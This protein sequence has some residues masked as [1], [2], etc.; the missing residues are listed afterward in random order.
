[1]FSAVSL[2]L[3]ITA[4]MKPLRAVKGYKNKDIRRE[5]NIDAISKQ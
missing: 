1:M 5:L 3:K 2:S 4:E